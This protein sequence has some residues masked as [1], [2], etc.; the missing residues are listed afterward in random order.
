MKFNVWK[1]LEDLS[2]KFK[3]NY[4]RTRIK[5]TL[6]E[7]QYIYLIISLSFLLRMR[8]VSDKLCRENQNTYIRILYSINVFFKYRAVYEI[9]WKNVV[10]P[11]RPQITIRRIRITCWKYKATNIHSECVILIA[12]PQQQWL[13][14]HVSLLHSAYI[15][16]LVQYYQ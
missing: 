3:F 15:A 16:C 12:F 7:H 6:H 1:F 13:C 9:M 2:G 5:G 14:K 11:D 8:N 10:E 4:N